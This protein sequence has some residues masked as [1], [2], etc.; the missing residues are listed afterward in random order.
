MKALTGPWSVVAGLLLLGGALK[1]ARPA[2]TAGALRALGLPAPATLVRL[3][4][5][6]EVMIAAG[7]LATG[8]RLFA[9]LIAASYVVFLVFVFVALRSE[10]P[11]SSC[12]CFGRVD[13]PPTFIH[14]GVNL[15]AAGVAVAAAIAPPPDFVSVVED[16]PAWGVPFV[17]LTLIGIYLAFLMMTELPRVFAVLAV[18]S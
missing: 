2:D 7:A 8:A 3:G 13:T 16:Q 11:L 1:A 6:T 17:F 9:V 14:V 18:D 15:A 12:G 10:T 5:T 4:A